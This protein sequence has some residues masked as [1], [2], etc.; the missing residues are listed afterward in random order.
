MYINDIHILWYFFIGLLGLFV[1]QFLDWANVRLENHEKVICKE[2]FTEYLH[3]IKI[4]AKLIYPM[5]LIYIGL[6]Y[7]F[8]LTLQLL[9]YLI[10]SPMLVSV[11]VIDYRKQIIP[12][13]LSLAIL[14]VALIFAFITGLSSS[15]LFLNKVLGMLVGGGTF[16]LITWIGGLIAGKEAMGFGDVKLMAGLGLMFGLMDTI[17]IAVSS[18][19]LGAVIS[20]ILLV[21]KKKK[22]D[23]Y[24]PFGPFIIIATFIVMVVPY[25][26]MLSILLTIF[27]LG[28]YK[29]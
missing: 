10:L 5:A 1:G 13:R 24:I 28:M 12:N 14:E 29:L 7:R 17:M 27:T 11:F 2:L 23:E 18:F 16:L 15:N 9:Q 4:N 21:T 25:N 20:I 19:L 26:T 8:G 6:L 22:G 3:N